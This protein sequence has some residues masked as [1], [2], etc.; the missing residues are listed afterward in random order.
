MAIEVKT[1]Y[2]FDPAVLDKAS[3]TLKK[4]KLFLFDMDGTIYLDDE[5]F[6]GAKEL[7]GE[8][9][10]RGGKYV[11][12]TNNSSKSRR[13]Y[14]E[15]L[16]RLGIEADEDDFFTSAMATAVYLNDNYPGKLAYCMGTRSM[17]DEMRRAGVRVTQSLEDGP[18][19]VLAGYDTELTYKKLNDVC[20]LLS[21]RPDMPYVAT[22]PDY[23]CPASYGFAPDLGCFMDMIERSCGRRPV[24]IG[25]PK[26][27]M[28]L[29]CEKHL[30][31]GG[32]ETVVVGDRIYTD[33][34]SGVNAGVTSVLVLSGE[35]KPEDIPKY[36]VKPTFVLAGVKMMYELLTR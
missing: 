36:D 15:K 14:V 30:G 20:Y 4:K 7:L 25:K 24:V 31:V 11:F 33:V 9:K 34:A 13:A 8:I 28:V 23:V 10:R 2:Y 1:D 22:H 3:K 6:A 26:P 17:M 21:T 29:S 12:I 16:T 5:L 19:L 32:D 27:A 35:T 18:E